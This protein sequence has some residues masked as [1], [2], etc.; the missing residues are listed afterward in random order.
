M[1]PL[2]DKGLGKNIMQA[3]AV[4]G[5][6]ASGPAYAQDDQ[7]SEAQ[8]AMSALAFLVGNWEGPGI[9]YDLDGSQTSYH[10]EE[11][12]RFDLDRNLLLINAKG[13]SKIGETLY[14]LHTIIY[15]DDAEG[16]YV[17]TPFSGSPPRSFRCSLEA[18][19]LGIKHLLC[20][21]GARDYR[22]VFQ[23]LTDGRW[24]EFGEALGE[25]G[26][27]TKSFETVLTAQDDAP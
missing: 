23:R 11:I 4:L 6:F 16:D 8:R 24:N 3:L 18:P 7:Q 27:W 25:D 2:K 19:P 15:Y 1:L 12:V 21:N 22:L 5:L 17:Y 9:S 14:S 10:D 26:I 20:L 13:Q